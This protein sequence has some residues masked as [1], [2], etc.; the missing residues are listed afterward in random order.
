MNPMN[1]EPDEIPDVDVAG[2]LDLTGDARVDA[3][4]GVA[5]E[6]V[7]EVGE[8]LAGVLRSRSRRLMGTLMRPHKRTLTFAAV[9]IV[10]NTAAQLA[11]PWL[12]QEGID[13]GIP[14]LLDGGSG[15]VR[16][17]ALVVLAYIGVTI[18]GAITFNGFLLITGRVG[19]DILLDVRR[20]VFVH[21]QQLSLSFHERY[22]SGRVISRQ[23]SDIEAIEQMLTY[24][25]V[26]LVTSVLLVVGIGIA[27]LLLDVR[28]ALAVLATF[29]V[30]WVL[31]RWFRNQSERA[32]RATRDAVAL[33]IVHFVE[34]LGGIQAVHAFR[35]EPRNQEIFDHLDGR[36]RDANMWSQRLAA[37]Y[38]PGVQFVGRLTTAVVLFYGGWMAVEGHLSVGALAAFLLYLRRFFEP[39][40][41]LSQFYNLFQAATAGLEKLSGVLDETPTVRPPAAPVPLPHARGALRLDGVEFAYREKIVLPHFDLTVPAGQ[42]LALVGA[43]GA[44]KTTVARLAA[45]FWDPT[46]GA[47]RLDDIDL[48]DLL[49]ADLRRAVSVVTQENFLFSGSVADNIALGRPGATR[50]EIVAAARAIGAD[51]FVNALADGYDT[52]VH[53]KGARL[54]AGQRQLVAFAR[55]FLA[56]PAVL[57]L[58]EAT[59]SLDIPSE[60]LVQ[61]AL[62]TLLADRTAMI[63]AHRL[64]T[65]EIADRVLVLEGGRIVEDGAPRDLIG[66]GGA[67]AG[68]H[69]AWLDSLV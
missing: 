37:A 24:G 4:R 26:T 5:A 52:D 3:W 16:P 62:R 21:F 47:V 61:R 48:R 25:V 12:V 31:T 43:T 23:T 49:E 15:S 19:Q 39:M 58:D 65:V 50:D 67:Y 64:T 6:D 69:R 30:L 2:P 22:T 8:G 51:D 59:S 13:R 27:M 66:R 32:Y 56:D 68:L 17:L 38:G 63:I 11:G 20:R 40:Q 1:V 60:R 10:A 42:T 45:R 36:Y 9:L 57:I 18:F 44:G 7:D 34:S 29:P 41:E 54:S 33:V 28:L 55:A 53:Q 14:P 35:R 46:V